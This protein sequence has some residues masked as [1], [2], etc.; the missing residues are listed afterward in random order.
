[1]IER[2]VVRC[3]HCHLSQFMTVSGSCRKC[4]KAL[5]AVEA[6]KVEEKKPPQA[7]VKP[8]SF[9]KPLPGKPFLVPKPKPEPK[10]EK[11]AEGCYAQFKA[12][13]SM[14]ERRALIRQHL[15]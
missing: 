4:R 2:V 12:A 5:A 10:R 11:L 3:Q 15:S 7:A 8:P 13:H 1:M 9:K 14:A 6:A